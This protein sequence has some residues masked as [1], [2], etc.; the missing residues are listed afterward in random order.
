M[1][2]RWPPQQPQKTPQE[3]QAYLQ[4]RLAHAFAQDPVLVDF[5][6]APQRWVEERRSAIEKMIFDVLEAGKAMSDTA[7]TLTRT[8]FE[9]A[10]REGIYRHFRKFY[11]PEQMNGEP[12][13]FEDV[14]AHE[15]RL[16]LWRFDLPYLS[17]S[18]T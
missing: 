18:N 17:K 15:L 2:D 12:E 3:A 10:L 8:Q 1:T 16:A 11:T 9:V 4:E 14:F 5:I 7:Q 6:E 13:V